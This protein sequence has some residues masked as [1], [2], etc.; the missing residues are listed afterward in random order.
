MLLNCGVGED[1]CEVLDCKEIKPVNPKENQSWI[2]I[3]RTDVEAEAAILWPLDAKNWLIRKDPDAGKDWMQE[4]KGTIEDELIGWHH[5][6]NGH[7]FEQAPGVGDGQ[8]S[9]ACCSPWGCKRVG[10]NWVTELKQKTS[11]SVSRLPTCRKNYVI[12]NIDELINISCI[13]AIP[14]VLASGIGFVEDNFF[15]TEVVRVGRMGWFQDDSNT[16]H[17]SCTLFLLLLH[18]DI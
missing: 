2:F 7:E 11:H 14:T 12:Y 6:L 5:W 8:G 4:E 18:C 16:L 1:S 17:L 3:G 15:T 9:L 13:S 10:H